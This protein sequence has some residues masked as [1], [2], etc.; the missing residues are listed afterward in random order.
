MTKLAPEQQVPPGRRIYPLD[1][2]ELSEEQ[3]AVAFAMT[4][5]STDPF[6][7]MAER[8]SEARAAEFHE[9]V[10]LNYGHASVAEHAVIHMAIENVSRL[11]CD[12]I[13]DNRLA[14]Y[15]ELSSRY[16]VIE[17]NNFHVPEELEGHG[18]R[19]EY[20]E[21]CRALFDAY[22][23]V[24]DALQEYLQ[25][26]V[27][28]GARESD[29]AY[30][31]RLQRRAI[32]NARFLLPAATL[33]NVGLTINA[34]GMEHAASKLLSSDLAESRQI[35]EEL[36]VQA[37]AVTPT[38]IKYADRNEYIAL[39]RAG[40]RE[41]TGRVDGEPS[42]G[43]SDTGRTP[44]GL[45]ARVVH[46]DPEA[47][48]KLAAALLYRSSSKPYAAAWSAAGRLDAAGRRALADEA[49]GRMGDHD[50]PLRELES[51]SYGFELVMD[52]GAYR[53]FSRHRMQ[54]YIA[55]PL[56]AENGFVTP[57]RVREAGLTA[58]FEDAVELSSRAFRRLSGEVPSV[59]PYV[60]THAHKRRVLSLM[61]LR[62]CYH[63][64][65]LRTQPTAH[66][67]LR[68]VVGAAMNAAK[69]EHPLLF[70]HLRLRS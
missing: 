70:E 2:R 5:R 19:G 16:L 52:Y 59:A 60:V 15:T 53:E 55:Q 28:Q 9:R 18:L 66:F 6:D 40:L 54:T 30:A 67:T 50:V 29:R 27:K 68:E 34:R 1:P 64:F 33:T 39:T 65:K 51:V 41:A 22:E 20:V 46:A 57:P 17:R 13:E 10:V 8:V 42:E 69:T 3:I 43:S 11:A 21:T 26:I 25:G 48:R 24:S 14:S 45:E 4:S 61:N 49:L 63:L 36:K 47:E 32:D 62:E 23:A 7:V 31:N 38:L 44:N 37:K 35:G 56:T 12:E 58:R